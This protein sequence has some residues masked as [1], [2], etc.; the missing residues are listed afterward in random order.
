MCSLNF[1]NYD[2]TLSNAY[3]LVCHW[4]WWTR[5]N[6]TASIHSNKP[7]RI[8]WFKCKSFSC[9][10]TFHFHSVLLFFFFVIFVFR[11]NLCNNEYPSH[12]KGHYC[13]NWCISLGIDISYI[14]FNFL[15]IHFL[16]LVY[17]FFVILFKSYTT[18]YSRLFVSQQDS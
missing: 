1:R 11:C 15:C 7:A 3:D 2:C 13:V 6:G 5:L 9:V 8:F 18:L 4:I 17:F 16:S 14:Y 10:N 12:L